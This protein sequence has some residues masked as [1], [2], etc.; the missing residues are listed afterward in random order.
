MKTRL[1]ED[2]EACSKMQKE[3]EGMEEP[4]GLRWLP[5]SLDNS[6]IRA[7]PEEHVFGPIF[8]SKWLVGHKVGHGAPLAK[9]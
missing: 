4:V 8:S 3:I 6:F 5:P 9:S 7:A 1:Q 2:P